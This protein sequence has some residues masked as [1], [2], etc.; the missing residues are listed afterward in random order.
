L[1]VQR[2]IPKLTDDAYPSYFPN[3]PSYLTSDPPTQ[4][5]APDTRRAEMISRDEDLFQGWLDSD[6]IETFEV[7]KAEIGDYILSSGY[8]WNVVK[9]LI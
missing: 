4:R 6:V 3:T 9:L 2:D 5:K 8:D 1:T 7:V